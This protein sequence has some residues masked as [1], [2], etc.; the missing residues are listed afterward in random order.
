M[1]S[2]YAEVFPS[3]LARVRWALWLRW[4]HLLARIGDWRDYTGHQVVLV[5][6]PPRR[7]SSVPTGSIGTAIEC[8]GPWWRRRHVVRIIHE[9]SARELGGFALR[10][11]GRYVRPIRSR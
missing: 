5:R 9:G 11:H 3:S 4:D 7:H 8:E 1:P 6:I 2:Q 10:R